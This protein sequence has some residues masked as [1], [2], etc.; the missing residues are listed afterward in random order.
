[1]QE[2]SISE[3]LKEKATESEKVFAVMLNKELTP[4]NIS[5]EI[6]KKAIAGYKRRRTRVFTSGK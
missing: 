4:E 5:D 6:V 3:A 2:W 1:M